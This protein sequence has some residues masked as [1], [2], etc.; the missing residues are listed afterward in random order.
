MSITNFTLKQLIT[1]AFDLKRP[2][3]LGGPGWIDSDRFDTE[4]RAGG[5]SSRQPRSPPNRQSESLV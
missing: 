4:T 3:V 2:Q 1:F 5:G